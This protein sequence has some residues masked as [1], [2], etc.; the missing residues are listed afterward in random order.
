MK[1]N[2]FNLSIFVYAVFIL[3]K[4]IGVIDWSWWWCFSPPLMILAVIA[5]VIILMTIYTAA[6][7][8]ATAFLMWVAGIF[9]KDN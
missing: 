2:L 9:D 4:L 5:I 1:V 7:A 6:I 3:L 8:L